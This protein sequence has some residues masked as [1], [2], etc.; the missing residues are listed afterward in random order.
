MIFVSKDELKQ[1]EVTT[2]KNMSHNEARVRLLRVKRDL[3][4]ME[5]LV[6]QLMR[7][8]EAMDEHTKTVRTTYADAYKRF[9]EAEVAVHNFVRGIK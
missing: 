9:K 5:Q 4:H 7:N 3:E 8:P 6:L 1:D 2:T